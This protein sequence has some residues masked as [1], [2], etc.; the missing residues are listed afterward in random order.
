MDD[1]EDD[2]GTIAG[3]FICEE[4]IQK[5]WRFDDET[6]TLLCSNMSTTDH[7]LTGQIVWPAAV[8]LSWF[9]NHRKNSFKAASV[10]ELGAGCGLSGFL[11]GVYSSKT[12]VTD[13]NEIVLR[14]LEQNRIFCKNTSISV[15]K[16]VWGI[17]KEVE[18]VT[19]VFG[20]PDIIIGADVVLWPSFVSPLLRTVRWLL[21]CKPRDS[22]CYISYVLRAVSTTNI[23][24]SVAETMDLTVVEIPAISFLPLEVAEQL[25]S[26]GGFLLLCL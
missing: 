23:F 9:V 6:V 22:V 24:L 25:G 26:E 7:D 2:G 4:Y 5:S 1:S 12:L 20:E 16:L 21:A 3:L 18:D 17:K 15:R 14:L 11:C 8:V 10:I 19:P 13:G